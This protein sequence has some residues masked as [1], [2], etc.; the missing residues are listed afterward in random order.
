MICISFTNSAFTRNVSKIVQKRRISEKKIT[1]FAICFF[2]V[3]NAS[4]DESKQQYANGSMLLIKV[5]SGISTNKGTLRKAPETLL[6]KCFIQITTKLPPEGNPS[7][8]FITKK[9]LRSDSVM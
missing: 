4:G 9:K 2:C 5:S 6:N 1:I 7:L 3:C 8:I